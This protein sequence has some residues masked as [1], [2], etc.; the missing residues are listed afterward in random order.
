M[1]R[2][3]EAMPAQDDEPVGQA[4]VDRREAFPARGEAA[5]QPY[6]L[7]GVAMPLDV[8]FDRIDA[9]IANRAKQL[10]ADQGAVED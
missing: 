3:S 9:L 10:R 6:L 2:W 7:D 8:V 1:P 4:P 5:W